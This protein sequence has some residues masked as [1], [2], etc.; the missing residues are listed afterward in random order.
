MDR[1]NSHTKSYNNILRSFEAMYINI[2]Y[3]PRAWVTCEEINSYSN[4]L[5]IVAKSEQNL[6]CHRGEKKW[7]F[8]DSLKVEWMF[9]LNDQTYGKIIETTKKLSILQ[10]RLH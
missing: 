7:R 6:L 10:L 2:K 3:E 4:L 8:S 9:A 1:A 5:K